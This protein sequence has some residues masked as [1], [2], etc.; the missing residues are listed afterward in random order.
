MKTNYMESRP[1]DF[2]EPIPKLIQRLIEE[3]RAL[4]PKLSKIETM[5]VSD[6]IVSLEELRPMILHHAVEEEARIMRVIMQGISKESATNSIQIMQEHRWVVNFLDQRLR[7]LPKIENNIAKLEIIKF[8]SDLKLHF[9]EEEQ[10]VFPLALTIY[11][12]GK[13]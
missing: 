2:S 7:E 11:S 6:S 12:K 8:I 13:P 9:E 10:G 4:C 3:H 1:V 5:S